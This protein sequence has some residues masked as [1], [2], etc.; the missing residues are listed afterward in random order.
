MSQLDDV[1][2]QPLS[3]SAINS[4]AAEWVQRRRF[5]DWTDQ[6]QVEL[7]KWLDASPAH[8]LAYLRMDAGYEGIG[9]LVA[10]RPGSDGVS[11]RLRSALKM[12]RLAAAGI[13]VAAVTGGAWLYLKQAPELRYET[14]LG[15]RETLLLQDGS[16]IELN[17]D[18]ALRISRNG[19]RRKAWL[20]KGEAYFQIK[21]DPR[22]PF[23]VLGTGY[24]IT[25]LGTKF[26]VRDLANRLEVTL[27]EGLARLD[28][29]ESGATTHSVLLKPGDAVR[30]SGTS[31]A[32]SR[33]S[34]NN[35]A[36]DLAWRSGVLTFHEKTLS[37]AAEEFN[38]YN[39]KKI[40]IADPD[41]GKFIIYG[42]F[43][44]NDVTAFADVAQAYFK[45]RVDDRDDQVTLSR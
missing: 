32:L 41:I 43:R 3:A 27:I 16:Q 13:L 8:R 22:H 38:R 5:W 9:R 44:S 6:D 19:D 15:D 14:R 34:S 1:A 35:L 40:V 30:Q 28:T 17:T 18:M 42:T 31:F 29:D 45:L 24:K 37:E 36:D 7:K 20:D 4:V 26:V 23:V 33:K 10:L 25:D 21:H 11:S 2:Q 39:R 12:P